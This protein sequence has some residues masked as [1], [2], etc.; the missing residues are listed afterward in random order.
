MG[1]NVYTHTECVHSQPVVTLFTHLPPPGPSL[2]SAW[3]LPQSSPIVSS[4]LGTTCVLVHQT[5]R[6]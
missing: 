3:V 6:S 2:T 1:Q 4:T 5:L